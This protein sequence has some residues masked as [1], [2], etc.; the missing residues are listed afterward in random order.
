MWIHF[1][2][3]IDHIYIIDK[4]LKQVKIYTV[5][6]KYQM[7]SKLQYKHSIKLKTMSTIFLKKIIWFIEALWNRINNSN[8]II[9]VHLFFYFLNFTETLRV[10]FGE[11]FVEHQFFTSCYVRK[12]MQRKGKIMTFSAFGIE[13]SPSPLPLHDR[14]ISN[15][16]ADGSSINHAISYKSRFSMLI[17]RVSN[18]EEQG[19]RCVAKRKVN[20]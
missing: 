5:H 3:I 10:Q 12:L 15:L 17:S 6:I 14:F 7:T 1:I 2:R 4:I 16:L 9:I 13:S 19:V 8:L 11:L 18:F 20:K